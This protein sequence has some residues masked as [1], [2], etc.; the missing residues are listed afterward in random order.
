MIELEANFLKIVKEIL[1]KHVPNRQVVVF[2]SRVK[3]KAK[4]FSDLDLC[5]MGTEPL[6]SET[7]DNLREAFAES[8]LPIRVD[9][10]EWASIGPEFREIIL[11][12]SEI[13][14]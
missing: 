3:S 9:L 2:G 7:L 13:F 11:H 1:R 5:I 8:D 12:K 4:Q 10:V 6:A 14:Q